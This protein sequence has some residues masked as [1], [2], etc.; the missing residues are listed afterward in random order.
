MGARVLLFA[1]AVLAASAAS[2]QSLSAVPNATIYPGEIIR[3]DMLRDVE[4]G[5]A[6]ESA[7]HS[8]AALIG[9]VARRTLLAGRPIAPEAVGEPQA[10]ANGAVVQIV[11]DNEGVRITATG[12]AMSAGSVGDGVRVRNVDSGLVVSGVIMRD[13]SVRVGG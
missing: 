10:I 13:G 2:A 9:K 1:T 7:Q 5:A 6:S 11:Y 4:G 3:S 12:Q 8:R